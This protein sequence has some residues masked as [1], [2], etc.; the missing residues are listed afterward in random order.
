MRI[1]VTL[2]LSMNSAFINIAS[3]GGKEHNVET[4]HFQ[5]PCMDPTTAK[6]YSIE[7]S[8]QHCG[9]TCIEPR[10]YKILK[11]F[12]AGLTAAIAEDDNYPCKSHGYDAYLNSPKHG[13]PGVISAQLDL[14]G[15]E[16]IPDAKVPNKWEF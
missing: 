10:K 3:A 4:P 1:V 7:E 6:Y 2:Y 5:G 14:Y 16:A 11:V 15:R 8:V 12:E 13:I 9:E